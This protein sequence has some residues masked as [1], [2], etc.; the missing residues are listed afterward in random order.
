M[1]ARLRDSLLSVTTISTV[2]CVLGLYATSTYNY[3]LFHSLTELFSIVVAFGIF[4]L[5]WNTRR[6]LENKLVLFLGIAY[7][8]VGAIDLIHTLAYQG[9]NVFPGY[10]PN[11]P[12]QLWIAARY[13]ESISLFVAPLVFS[14]RFCPWRLLVGYAIITVLLML[15]IFV[16][17]VF[18]ECFVVGEGLTTFKVASEYLISALLLGSVFLLLRIRREFDS[19][20]VRLLVAS[21]AV[22]VASEIVFTLFVSLY[23]GFNLLGHLLKFVSFVLI[24]KAVVETGLVRPYDLL[25]RDLKLSEEELRKALD[26]V[27]TLHGIVPICMYCKQ[28]RNDEGFWRGVE[29]YVEAHS[30]AQF[31]HGICP[32]CLAEHYPELEAWKRKQAARQ[33]EVED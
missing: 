20:V 22:T 9:M 4:V 24:Y 7:A 6:F 21:V 15:T 26:E 23:G 18:P 12:T 10:G 8:F 16:W 14:S 11:L 28:V 3:L 25:F 13:L 30:E 33:Q 5:A 32:D 19:L 29:F 17:D 27:R 31:S 1:M 2:L